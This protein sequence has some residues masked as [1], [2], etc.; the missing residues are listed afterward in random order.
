MACSHWR[1]QLG[2]RAAV[3]FAPFAFDSVIPRTYGVI[4]PA[5]GLAALQ[6]I[7]Q[8]FSEKVYQP[9]YKNFTTLIDAGNTDGW[10]RAALTLLNQGDGVLCS[11]WTYP[12]ALAVS[13]GT[14]HF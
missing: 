7:I 12:S 13:F 1:P 3:Q 14:A 11:E 5:T 9:G 8:E 10:G 6:K 2:H 4:G